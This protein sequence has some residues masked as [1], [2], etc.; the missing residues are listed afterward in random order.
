MDDK[1]KFKEGEKHSVAHV[2]DVST[3]YIFSFP[4]FICLFDD[5]IS[6]WLFRTNCD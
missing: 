6:L 3:M 1:Y 2:K 4:C 5:P